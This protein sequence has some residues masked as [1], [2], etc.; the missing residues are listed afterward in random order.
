[1]W[2]VLETA[3]NA[4]VFAGLMPGTDRKA[5]EAAL[6]SGTIRNLLQTVPVAP[7]DA[8]F[9]PGGRVHAI[10]AGCLLLEVQQNSNTTYRI[11]DWGRVGHDGRPRQT[12]LDQALRAI[13]WSDSAPVKLT[14]RPLPCASPTVREEMLC[15]P[16]F[17]VE[18][19]RLRTPVSLR[20]D[21]ESFAVVF[22]AEG[23]VAAQWAHGMET[24]RSGTTVLVPAALPFLTLR[25][26][27]SG[28]T[29]IMIQRPANPTQ[30]AGPA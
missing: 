27:E 9:V 20:P 24:Y 30:S 25:P 8:V 16:F 22:V 21:G 17:R 2:Y 18:R 10:D 1:M 15:C 4:R 11:H 13:R 23:A 14:P 28:A 19:W 12:H 7:G 6:R 3:P 26:A 29:L 5:F